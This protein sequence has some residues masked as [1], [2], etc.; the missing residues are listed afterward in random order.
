M[1]E[2]FDILYRFSTDGG[3]TWVDL[4]PQVDSRQT[5]LT[6]NLCTNNFTSAKDEATFVMPETPLF[7]PDGVTPTPKK[8]LIDALLGNSDILIHINAP[9][10]TQ[11]VLWD[12]NAVVWNGMHVCW[13]DSG[14]RFT[15]YADRSAI[16]IRSFPLPP[17]ITVK[18][19]DV[20]VLH[21][22][23]KV[24]M[25]IC[26]ESYTVKTIVRNLLTLAG[27]DA[28]HVSLS[29]ADTTVM[30]AT[31]NVTLPF[32]VD[33]DKAKTYRQYI[34]LLLFEAGGYVIDFTEDG[35]VELVHLAW[36]GTVPAVRTIDNPMNAEGVQM[37][38]AWLKEDGAKVTWSSLMWSAQEQLWMSDID[39]SIESGVLVGDT[40][41]PNRYWP[42]GA[43]LKPQYFEYDAKLL[44]SAYRTRESRRQNEDLTIIMAKN[45]NIRQDAMQGTTPFTSWDMVE[46]TVWPAGDNWKD[47]YGIPSNPALWATKAWVLL[48]NN[49]AQDINLT[50]FT[51]YGDVLYR[52]KLNTMET[53]GTKNPKEYESTYIYDEAQ[54]QRFVQFYWHFLQTS[55]YQF[56]WS[57]PCKW[58]ELNE[59]VAVG[60][61]GNGSTQKALIASKKS[62][63]I[64][65]NT[66]ILTYTAIGVDTYTPA[67]LVP[68]VIVP[69]TAKQTA[70]RPSLT[71]T[72]AST[73]SFTLSQWEAYGTPS[74][75]QTWTVTNAS[76]F[77]SG[78][79][80]LI[81]GQ[82][83]DLDDTPVTLYMDVTAVDTVNGTI[84]GTG[85]R[86][87]YTVPVNVD[88]WDFEMEASSA[89]RNDRL[90]PYSSL[91]PNSYTDI[92]LTSLQK[93]YG[94]LE[95]WSCTGT[96]TFFGG[97]PGTQTTS[98]SAPILRIAKDETDPEI[99]VT[100]HSLD[101]SLSIERKITI[102]NETE[103]DHDFGAWS[104]PTLPTYINQENTLVVLDGDF[105][106]AST[107]FTGDDGQSYVMG[108]PYIYDSSKA[109][110]WHNEMT[111]TSE[112]AVRMLK[113]LASTLNDENIQPS[114]A[115]LYGWFKNLIAKSAVIDELTS[116]TAFINELNGNNALFN[117]IKITGDSEFHGV[118]QTTAF[119]TTIAQGGGAPYSL[120]LNTG[121]RYWGYNNLASKLNSLLPSPGY[122][123][124]SGTYSQVRRGT[125]DILIATLA[126]ASGSTVLPIGTVLFTSTRNQTVVVT[127]SG[128]YSGNLT[129]NG[130]TYTLNSSYSQYKKATMPIAAGSQIVVTGGYFALASA[131]LVMYDR[132]SD[133][134]REFTFFNSSG[135]VVSINNYNTGYVAVGY[136]GNS[137]TSDA[138]YKWD[139]MGTASGAGQAQSGSISITDDMGNVVAS[140]N[141]IYS[142]YWDSTA[143]IKITDTSLNVFNVNTSTYY[144]AF[145]A[146]FQLLAAIDS[147][148]SKTIT[149]K[150]NACG[151]GA[152]DNPFYEAWIKTVNYQNLNQF[153]ARKYKKDIETFKGD[154][155]GIINSTE[156]VTFSYIDDETK[157][158]K[159]GFIADDTPEE[160]SGKNH[161]VMDIGNCI[162]VLMKAIQ[163]LSAR[164]EELEAKK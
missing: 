42:D 152:S 41:E 109:N 49:T 162:G 112:N 148:Q 88:N 147:V 137:V 90:A 38:G 164:V 155:L 120:G 22:D 29:E 127:G 74:A 142:V 139:G 17:N 75:P 1:G 104:A 160:L 105:F 71:A 96:N 158:R 124:V 131:S 63:W 108:V 10:P 2:R 59:V 82:I 4:T 121:T 151:L 20:S 66:E 106:V 30:S 56:T 32:V 92:Q 95:Y 140:S 40:V 43:E 76:S 13:S 110:P 33:K 98:G 87:D 47:K 117:S 44:D 52:Y 67:T 111:A 115:A 102:I 65:G 64:N 93:G 144:Q 9:F 125:G 31:D 146:T 72:F 141:P 161:D 79:I 16:D 83:S 21:L 91:D 60:I 119:T 55:R 6:H 156:I 154:A 54:A 12:D 89:V 51:I 70:V 35:H 153:S 26:W 84:S 14:R 11:K 114:T 81:L 78:Y 69:S 99:T 97:N 80:A 15:G 61:K 122:Y 163:E 157:R 77:K 50:F 53:Q 133:Y 8:K 126:S 136:N 46:P 62:K 7:E 116:N 143:A 86:I 138:L 27:Y 100:M 24:D 128:M 149:P 48:H 3:S 73:P 36:D 123:S 135:S 145:T 150:D 45:I 129:C 130:V 159:I 34:D 58:N 103:Y 85:I 57:E 132:G 118:V 134:P 101:N 19:Q 18:V 68:T 37:R 25:H 94:V 113:C 23:D 39:Q 107:D 5:V 28:S